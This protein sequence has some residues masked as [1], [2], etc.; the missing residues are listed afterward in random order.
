MLFPDDGDGDG[1]LRNGWARNDLGP[2]SGGALLLKLLV[3][4]VF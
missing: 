3:P 4:G 1:G 2:A